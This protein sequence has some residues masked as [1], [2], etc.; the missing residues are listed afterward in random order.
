MDRCDSVHSAHSA[1]STRPSEQLSSPSPYCIGGRFTLGQLDRRCRASRRPCL[2]P[3]M[4]CRCLLPVSIQARGSLTSHIQS[5]DDRS[6]QTSP[7]LLSVERVCAGTDTNAERLQQR[8]R[9]ARQLPSRAAL[10]NRS[11]NLASTTARRASPS[12][13]R[14]CWC[15][16]TRA[17][18]SPPPSVRAQSPYSARPCLLIYSPYLSGKFKKARSPCSSRAF[19]S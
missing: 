18:A 6:S 19:A 11:A 1:D 3:E 16:C 8:K 5:H 7:S 12:S 13:S 15:R 4:I 2:R 9:G 10:A 14:G 17:C